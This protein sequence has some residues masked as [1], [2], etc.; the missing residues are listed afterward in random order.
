MK[1][2]AE[3]RT[4]AS[5]FTPLLLVS[6]GRQSSCQKIL[7]AASCLLTNQE[8]GRACR[9]GH[10]QWMLHLASPYFAVLRDII[11]LFE[12]GLWYSKL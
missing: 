5:Y 10:E 11:A 2:S 8:I 4:R 1:W 6:S 12:F 3:I 7:D 9:V